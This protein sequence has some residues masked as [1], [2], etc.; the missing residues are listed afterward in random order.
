MGVRDLYTYDSQ[1][2]TLCIVCGSSIPDERQGGK[3]NTCSVKCLKERSK[4]RN[5]LYDQ[6]KRRTRLEMRKE[7]NELTFS[8]K[9]KLT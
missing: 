8:E 7:I 3:K 2:A 9:K 4:T 6:N 5:Q 1:I